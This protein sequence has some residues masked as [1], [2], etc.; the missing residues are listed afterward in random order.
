MKQGFLIE[1]EDWTETYF[2]PDD[3]SGRM[4][5]RLYFAGA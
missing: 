5:R 1:D 4:V 2:E 3:R